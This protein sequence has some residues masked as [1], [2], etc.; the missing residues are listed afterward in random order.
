VS[1]CVDAS[2][3]ACEPFGAP[4]VVAELESASHDFNEKPT[5]TSDLLTIYFLSDRDGGS[6]S[7][8]IWTAA[9][10]TPADTWGAPAVVAGVNDSSR[11]TSPA[12]SGDG[13]TLW[14]ASDRDGGVG[15][16]DIWVSALA[17][18]AGVDGGAGWSSPVPVVELN[19]SG[20]EIPRPPGY[21]GLI[22]PLSYRSDP[23]A[24]YRTDSATRATATPSATW[25]TPTPIASVNTAGLNDDGFLTD[26]GLTLYFSS[27]RLNG[28]QDLFVTERPDLASPF[29][30]PLALASLNTSDHDERDPWVSPDGR[31]IFFASDRLGK[32]QIFHATR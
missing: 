16:L 15:G 4:S 12:I 23:D 32:L 10:A 22:M 25:S 17:D 9:R 14:F 18:D 24:T 8:D 31:E 13:T 2:D 1:V 30:P 6:G 11:E 26:D 29:A 3:I 19:S 28:S 5:L 20:D 27:D 21:H 7:G